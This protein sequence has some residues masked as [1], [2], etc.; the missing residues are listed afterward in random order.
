MKTGHGPVLPLSWWV[1]SPKLPPKSGLLRSSG[2]SFAP[3]TKLEPENRGVLL[4]KRNKNAQKPGGRRAK[5]DGACTRHRR[6]ARRKAP[7]ARA[8]PAACTGLY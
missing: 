3:D 8:R 1:L 2:P 7:R 4:S 6:E 5:P